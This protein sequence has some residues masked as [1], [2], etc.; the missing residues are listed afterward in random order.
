M[1]Q[2]TGFESRYGQQFFLHHVVQ[3]G[4]FPGGKAAAIS[5]GLPSGLVRK[6]KVRRSRWPRGLRHELCSAAQTLESLVRIPLEVWMS[7]CAFILCAGI[8]LPTG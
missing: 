4:S 2:G 7:L 5:T 1:I 8:G 6:D 3:T